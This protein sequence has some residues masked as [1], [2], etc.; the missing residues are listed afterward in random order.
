MTDKPV[1][2]PLQSNLAAQREFIPG[3]GRFA[4]G[5]PLVPQDPQPTR[6]L[7][8][9]VG[10]NSNIRPRA[11]EA[12]SFEE[13][14]AFSGVELVRLAIETRKDQIERLD[15]EVKVKKGRK[16]RTDAN[17]RINSVIRFLEKPDGI[18]PFASWMRMLFEDLLVIDAATVERRRTR[19]GK[20]IGL[21]VIDGSTIKLLIDYDGRTPRPP[22]PAYQQIIKGTV[23]ND[24]SLD[25]IIYSP[26]NKRPGKLYGFSPVE[27]IVITLNT[28]LRRQQQQLAYFTDGNTPAGLIN[29]PETWTIDQVKEFQEWFDG[30][31]SGN[32]PERAKLLMT[33]SG[34][35]YQALKES[36]FKDEFDEWMA[37]I[38]C[39]AF[40]LPPTPFVKQMNKATAGV[41]DERA[42]TEGLDPLTRWAKR[43][44][45]GVIQQD[46][47]YSDLEFE[48]G[49]P[50]EMDPDVQSIINDRDIRNGTRTVDEVRAAAGLDPIPGGNVSR[51]YIA[52]G[53]VPINKLDT[54]SE[55]QPEPDKSAQETDD[56]ESE[57]G[58]VSV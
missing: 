23:W 43:L 40:S 49:T 54:I 1:R 4:P 36:P 46:I 35:Q 18:N 29:V 13:L 6:T 10:I 42:L 5:I 25:D 31:L 52:S 24:L 51:V 14:R 22:F 47:G 3:T 30:N 8:Y 41:L 38:V 50:R 17:E 12:F 2:I 45:D 11:Y 57:Q 33:P 37:R 15:W 27:Q 19:S 48:W 26:R 39:Y 16:A 32:I 34:S 21:D 28:S 55:D 20:L 56:T 9:I 58:S 53:A 7:D 44:I